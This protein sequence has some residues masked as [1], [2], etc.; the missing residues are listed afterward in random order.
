MTV[1]QQYFHR[2]VYRAALATSGQ[3][4]LYRRKALLEDQQ[5]WSR[6]RLSSYRDRQLRGV[7]STALQHVP[8]YQ[9]SHLVRAAPE[10]ATASGSQLREMLGGFPIIRK[11]TLREHGDVMAS[12]SC[13]D[14]TLSKTTGGS[15]GEPVTI[16]KNAPAVAQERA[17]MWLGYSWFGV[18]IGDRCMRFWGVPQRRRQK[19][20]ARLGDLAMN[21]VRAS[22]FAFSDEDL[23]SYWQ[24]LRTFSPHYLHGYASML[25]QLADYAERE[26][27]RLPSKVLKSVVATAEVLAPSDQARLEEVFGAPV[28]VEYG[29]GEVG[30]IAYTCEKGQLHQILTNVHVEILD[31]NER[32]ASDGRLVITD[33]HNTAMPLIRYEVGDIGGWGTDCSCGRGFPV[34]DSIHGRAYD[35]VIAPD[36]SRYHGE[37]FMYLFE[38]LER[39]GAA[40][41]QF[42]VLQTADDALTVRVVAHDVDWVT[43]ERL[44][45]ACFAHRLPMFSVTIQ[46][47]GKIE[48]LPSGKMQVVSGLQGNR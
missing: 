26:G 12:T 36:G 43:Q 39:E 6:D 48:R 11:Q 30:P 33:L 37:F 25:V 44:L 42:Q 14:R 45:T 24:Q 10:V 3:T 20:L 46:R 29:C 7:L 27:V 1:P 47:V 19:W 34:L 18:G 41:D 9:Q 2:L 38:D 15:T 40:I 21:R 32:P 22:S 17:A 16:L 13:S 28:Q 8:F 4:S 31:D 23:R 35:I 5:H